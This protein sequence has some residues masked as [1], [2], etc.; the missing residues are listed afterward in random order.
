MNLALMLLAGD[1]LNPNPTTSADPANT[2]YSPGL[3]GFLGTFILVIG[4]I[5]LIFDLVRRIR[6]VNYRAQIQ[7]RLAAEQA[8]SKPA[9]EGRKRPAPPAKPKRE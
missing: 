1:P 3:I 4:A 2:F 9:S 7:E 6:R 5:A 8:E